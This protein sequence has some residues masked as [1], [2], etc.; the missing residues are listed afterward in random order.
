MEVG[1]GSGQPWFE[2]VRWGNVARALV[3]ICA[4]LVVVATLGRDRGSSSELPPDAGLVAPATPAPPRREQ[5]P[6]KRRPKASSP[7][8]RAHVRRRPR[9]RRHERREVPVTPRAPAPPV[10]VAPAPPPPAN[11]FAP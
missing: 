5:R 8:R 11:E 10:P 7:S 3:V 2:R 6:V 4:L 1:G 9:R